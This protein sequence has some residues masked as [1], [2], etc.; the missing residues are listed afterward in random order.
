MIPA[1][2]ATAGSTDVPVGHLGSDEAGRDRLTPAERRVVALAAEGLS[3]GQIPD[4]H[5]LWSRVG[6][7]NPG[8]I[9]YE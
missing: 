9:H 6:E 5:V 1:A 4:L 8:P 3:N 7:S 2:T